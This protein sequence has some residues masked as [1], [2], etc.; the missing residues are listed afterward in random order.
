MKISF[1][2]RNGINL[3]QKC[4]INPRSDDVAGFIASSTLQDITAVR[5]VTLAPNV[6]K[7]EVFFFVSQ[8]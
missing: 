7:I 8:K 2:P 3:V 6:R 1:F 4:K 5:S